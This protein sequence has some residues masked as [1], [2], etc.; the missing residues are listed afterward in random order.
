MRALRPVWA[1]VRV[2]VSVAAL[3][4]LALQAVLGGVLSAGLSWQEHQLCLQAID[5]TVSASAEGGP[6]KGGPAHHHHACC[7]AAQTIAPFS[8]PMPV[9]SAIAWPE[10]R[11]IGLTWRPEVAAAPRA[12]PSIRPNAR[13]PPVV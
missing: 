9:A 3:Y 7:T 2:V 1:R 4:A 12:P 11:A 8:A 5:T 10:R 6:T 13:A